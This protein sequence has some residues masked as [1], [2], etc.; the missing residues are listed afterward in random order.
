MSRKPASWEFQE[1]WTNVSKVFAPTHE[2][3]F[4][5]GYS[6]GFKRGIERGSLVNHPWLKDEESE[7]KALKEARK[8]REELKKL[9]KELD[10]IK[11][12]VDMIFDKFEQEED[13]PNE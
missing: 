9:I 12:Q 7:D 6:I 10:E 5:A 13:N 11:N 2:E 8:L 3:S 1:W 4:G